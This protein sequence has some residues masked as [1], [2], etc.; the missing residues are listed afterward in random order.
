MKS[1][2]ESQTTGQNHCVIISIEWLTREDIVTHDTEQLKHAVE[3]TYLALNIVISHE[4][5]E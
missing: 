5:R 4:I 1:D 3:H 2:F